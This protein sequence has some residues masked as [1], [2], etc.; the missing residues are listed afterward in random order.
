MQAHE[1]L[2]RLASHSMSLKHNQNVRLTGPIQQFQRF[3]DAPTTRFKTRHTLCYG[4]AWPNSGDVLPQPP[5]P[6]GAHEL[7]MSVVASKKGVG[8]RA[9]H[10][11]RA[12]RRLRMAVREVLAHLP[13]GSLGLAEGP[14]MLEWVV[15]AN[16]SCV[17][18]AWGELVADVRAQWDRL[19]GGLRPVEFPKKKESADGRLP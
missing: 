17:D 8:K 1:P 12:K 13:S 5:T 3:F 6:A 10:R 16:K 9:V 15:M 18:C 14:K 7:Q 11:N 19:F 2:L 4:L